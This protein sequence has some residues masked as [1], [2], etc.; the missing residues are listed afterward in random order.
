MQHISAHLKDLHE[1]ASIF[2]RIPAPA[3]HFSCPS[4]VD[5]ALSCLDGISGHKLLSCMT[6]S[7]LSMKDTFDIGIDWWA[8]E[9]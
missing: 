4:S 9:K 8:I 3:S 1:V 7:H 2:G 5:D 6:M